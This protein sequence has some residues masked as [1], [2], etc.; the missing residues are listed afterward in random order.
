[1]SISYT[2]DETIEKLEEEIRFQKDFEKFKEFIWREELG[3]LPLF[4]ANWRDQ[5]VQLVESLSEFLTQI[6][7]FWPT[8]ASYLQQPFS[9][10]HLLVDANH[11]QFGAIIFILFYSR[12]VRLL[13]CKLSEDINRYSTQVV[14]TAWGDDENLQKMKIVLFID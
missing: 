1:M 4:E 3:I 10:E 7:K 12:E 11:Q 2:L 14:A 8:L 5:K 9:G 6:A 13:F